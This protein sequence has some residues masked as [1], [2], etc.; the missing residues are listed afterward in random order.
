MQKVLVFG[1]SGLVG[2]ACVQELRNEFD[3]YGTYYSSSSTGL[4]RDKQF[5]LD[6]KELEIL[7]EMI[8]AIQPDFVISCLQGEYDLQ[9]TF[10]R[11]LAKQLQKSSRLYYISTTNVFDGDFTKSHTEKDAPLAE[12]DYGQFKIECE[13]I[14]RELLGER[15][16]IVRI[17]AIWGKDSPRMN[18]IRDSIKNNKEIE[19]YSNLICNNL[20]DADLAKQLHYIIKNNIKGIV[21][22][23]SMD[24]MTQAQFFQQI[25][26]KLT[27]DKNIL[28][29]QLFNE[30]NETFYFRLASCRDELPKSLQRNNQH[31]IE[32]LLRN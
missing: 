29:Y 22:L 26:N 21:H 31:L 3:V 30:V 27:N 9:L 19:V 12:S 16:V 1:A 14:L 8:S 11:E 17:P 4:P 6:I 13:N 23:G 24:M 15:A 5:R 7:K 2:K 28:K 10:H 32:Y 25:V 18:W 20:L